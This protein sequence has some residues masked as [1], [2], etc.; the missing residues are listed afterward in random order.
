MGLDGFLNQLPED[1]SASVNY[2]SLPELS[3]LTGPE[4]EEFGQLWLEWSPER[5]LEIVDRMVA[6]CEEQPDVEFEAIYKQGLLHPSVPVRLSALRGLEES[7]DRAL[8]PPLTNMLLTDPSVEVRAASAIPLT[9]L[10]ALAQEKKL[11]SKDGVTLSRVLYGVLDDEREVQAV[12]LKALEA[13]S[14]FGGDRLASYV[15]SA[16]SSTD[17]SALKSSLFAMGRSSDPKWIDNVLSHLEHDVASIR[18]EAAMAMGELGDEEH[19][20]ALEVPLDDADLTVQLAAISAVERIGGEVAKGLLELLLVSPEPRVVELVQ[21]ALQ[22]MKDEED[23]DEVVTQEMAR[24]MFGAGDTLP[25]VDTEG[26]EPAEIEGWA[27]LPDPSEVDDFGTGITEEAEELG[28]DRGDP[29][30]V[31]LPPEDPWDHEE[32]F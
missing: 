17:I 15:E 18:Y 8:I 6:L 23:L 24:S 4:A 25:G 14:V 1:E 22:T 29:F 16:A 5:V 13:V 30:D 12:R 31:D 7:G 9:Y 3:K 2:A 11:G 19:L 26:Y 28:L 20:H 32:N 10:S 21:Q 27:N